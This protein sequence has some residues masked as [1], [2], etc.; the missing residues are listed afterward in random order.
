MNTQIENSTQI[1]FVLDDINAY[2]NIN[3]YLS[4][5]ININESYIH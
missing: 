1:I 3:T 4:I 2:I 5:I